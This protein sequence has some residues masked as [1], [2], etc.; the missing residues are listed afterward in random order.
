MPDSPFTYIAVRKDIPLAQQIVQACHASLEMGFDLQRPC[1]SCKDIVSL[2][3]LQVENEKELL[4]LAKKIEFHNIKFHVFY[5]PE[6][7]GYE[8]SYTALATEPIY[9]EH[10]EIFAE[11][12]M[13]KP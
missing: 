8:P 6:N 2:I 13:W 7:M 10:R 9:D 5:E 11:Y 4:E 12:K 1:R 3:L